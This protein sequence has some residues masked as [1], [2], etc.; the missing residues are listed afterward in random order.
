MRKNTHTHTHTHTY[1][2][3]YIYTIEPLYND[4]GLCVA[5]SIASDILWNE[6][7]YLILCCKP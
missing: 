2:Y 4:I 6:L 3:I 1:I 7:I 5:S